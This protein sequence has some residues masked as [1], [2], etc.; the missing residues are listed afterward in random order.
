V[1]AGAVQIEAKYNSKA[2]QMYKIALVKKV[3]ASTLQIVA[4]E[5]EEVRA[6]SGRWVVGW[7]GG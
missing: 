1:T 5:V 7:G 2:A 6:G 4:P 3:K